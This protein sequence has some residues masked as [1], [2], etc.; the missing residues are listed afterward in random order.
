MATSNSYAISLIGLSGSLVEVE[1]DLS[2]NLPGFVIVGLPD[3][4]LTEAATRVRS[5]TTNSG[6][7]L[8]NR[9]LTVNLSPAAVPK[10]GSSFDLAIAIAA[11]RASKTIENNRRMV[12]VG[13]LGLDGA[14]RVVRGVLPAVMAAKNFGFE[15]V[16]VPSA[17]LAEAQLVSGI[18]VIAAES[19]AHAAALLGV[20]IDYAGHESVPVSASLKSQPVAQQQDIA[21]VLG[22]SEAINALIVAA[23]GGHH[24]LM[25]GSPGVGKTMLAER[26]PGLLPDLELESAL[27]T[28]AVHSIASGGLNVGS[29]LVSRPP[30]ENPHHTASVS[31]LIGGGLRIP[32]PGLVS[33]AHNGVLFLDEAPEF[34]QPALEAMRQCLESGQVNIARSSG[35]ARFPARFQLVLAAN[36]C[37]CGYAMSRSS[38]CKCS[39]SSRQKYLARLSGPLL[40]RIDIRIRVAEANAAQI[41]LDRASNTRLTTAQAREMVTLAR[42]R[43]RQRNAEFG[44]ALNAHAT[45]QLLRNKLFAKTETALLDQA[46]KRGQISM[47]GYDRCLRLAL[48]LADLDDNTVSAAHI[49]R[50]M[51]LRG[52]DRFDSQ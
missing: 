16:M 3:A 2:S 13:E 37:P 23:A 20:S 12:F 31:A 7:P 6:L 25:I 52:E 9:K 51:M 21:D 49:S 41:A 32:K 29:D 45:G 11:L 40:D 30:I 35:V 33:L 15:A 42:A 24:L 27:E 48:T 10:F 36:P 46:V 8:P 19:L 14:L 44:F 22:Q 34:Q 50:A 5:A 17:N 18:E 26:L 28:T 43:A 47:R 1:A 38:K 39:A 4:S